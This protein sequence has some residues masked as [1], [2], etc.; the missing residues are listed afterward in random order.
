[1]RRRRSCG[2]RP[3]PSETVRLRV[4]VI[5][6]FLILALIAAGVSLL[7]AI[8]M[9][10]KRYLVFAWQIFKFA[11]MLILVFAALVMMGRIILYGL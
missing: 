11:L 9:R 7:M 6:L 10:D 4:I 1:M 8:V 3:K 2:Y 5:R